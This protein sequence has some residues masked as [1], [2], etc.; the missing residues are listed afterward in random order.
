MSRWILVALVV[1]V[2]LAGCGDDGRLEAGAAHT[3][4]G[5]VEDARAAAATGDR[6][7]ALRALDALERR[8][9]REREGGGLAEADAAGMLE[10]IALARRRVGREI[11]ER[12]PTVEPTATAVPPPEPPPDREG[13]KKDEQKGKGETEGKGQDKGKGKREGKGEGKEGGD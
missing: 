4:H 9:R 13:D 1:A 12:Q 3:M 5:D 11:A 7:R 8:V 6:E 10:R 2:L